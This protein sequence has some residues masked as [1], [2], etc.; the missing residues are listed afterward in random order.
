MAFVQQENQKAAKI[1][2]VERRFNYLPNVA[3]PS[4]VQPKIGSGQNYFLGA[5]EGAEKVTA[6]KAVVLERCFEV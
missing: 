3:A 6:L 2:F 1:T 4:S 5:A